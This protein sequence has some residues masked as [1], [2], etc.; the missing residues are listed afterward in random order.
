LIVK[1]PGL[2]WERTHV[3]YDHCSKSKEIMDIERRDRSKTEIEFELS[4][5]MKIEI[6]IKKPSTYLRFVETYTTYK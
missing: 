3:L 1:V 5:E 4:I 6:E 2:A